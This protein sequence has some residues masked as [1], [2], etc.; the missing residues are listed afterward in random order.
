MTEFQLGLAYG[1]GTLYA[2]G[3][4]YQLLLFKDLEEI[5]ESV[6]GPVLFNCL[7][8]PICAVVSVVKE[9]VWTIEDLIYGKDDDDEE[10]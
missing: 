5:F 4:I 10:R 2:L 1:S 3:F 7:I 8:W 6:D 9:I